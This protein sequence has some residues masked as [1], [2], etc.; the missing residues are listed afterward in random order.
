LGLAVLRPLALSLFDRTTYPAMRFFAQVLAARRLIIEVTGLPHVPK[1]GPVLVVAR[2]YHHLFDGIGLLLSMPRPIHILVSLD[3]IKSRQARRLMQLATDMA[4]W[5][6]VVRSDA[7]RAGVDSSHT[8]REVAFTSADI[9]RYQRKA[10]CDSVE[11]LAQG[12][13]LVVFPEGYPN[14]DPHYTPKT[15]PEEFLRFESG[16][17]AIGGA[18]EKR[19]G[20]KVPLLPTGLVYT[21]VSQGSR[22][23]VR[24]NIGE[25]VYS[26]DFVSRRL[27]VNYMEQRVAELS[28]S[29]KLESIAKGRS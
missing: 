23:R 1:H 29:V 19:L 20:A 5:P 27:L 8:K 28:G 4:R 26:E 16:F 17:A 24:L 13:I 7:L 12:R 25:P 18:A 9:K 3:W 2:H 14:I 21:K 22:W 10:L 11:L 6:V 15:R